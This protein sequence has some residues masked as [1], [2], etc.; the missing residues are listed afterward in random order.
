MHQWDLGESNKK[1]SVMSRQVA[2]MG[3]VETPT[4]AKIVNYDIEI[5][6]LK[7][8]KFQRVLGSFGIRNGRDDHILQKI[9][10]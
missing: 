2:T 7:P 4:L 3:R 8:T 9:K 5:S 6:N 1:F 10:K